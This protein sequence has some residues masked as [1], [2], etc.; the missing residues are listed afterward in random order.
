[1]ESS[2]FE[3]KKYLAELGITYTYNDNRKVLTFSN[4]SI[5]KLQ[6]LD[7]DEDELRGPEWSCIVIDEAA[8]VEENKYYTLADRARYKIGSRKIRILSNSKDVGPAHWI[9]TNYSINPKPH[10]KLRTVTTYMNRKNLP[11]DYIPNLERRYPPGSALHKRWMLGEIIRM[12]G[13]IYPEFNQSF[14]VDKL[15]QF[16][17]TGAGV[18]WGTIDPFVILCGG[19]DYKGNLYIYEQFYQSGLAPSQYYPELERM[20]R[21]KATFIDHSAREMAEMSLKGFSVRYAEKSVLTGI[22]TVRNRFTNKAIFIHSSCADLIREL[23]QYAWAPG[24]AK[25]K[26]EHKYSHSPDALR[27]LIM[28][29]D[30]PVIT[31]AEASRVA[32]CF[33]F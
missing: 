25:E 32:S 21:G 19:V 27:Y 33:T 10:H 4:K 22:E 15:P 29:I 31:Q 28:G 2:F 1:M 16:V 23:Y 9:A 14:I 11:P 26:P 13:V 30:D 18:D 12:E 24:S 17:A 20:C 3:L 5:I 8:Q 6:T 7:V